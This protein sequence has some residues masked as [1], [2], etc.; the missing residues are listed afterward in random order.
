MELRDGVDERET[1]A[2]A[3]G[4]RGEEGL[5]GSPRDL[6]GDTGAGVRDADRDVVTLPRQDDLDATAAGLRV[7]RVCHEVAD[8][9]PQLDTVGDERE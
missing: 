5:A 4:A 3:V 9:L 8:G 7:D 2:G 1:E 6:R